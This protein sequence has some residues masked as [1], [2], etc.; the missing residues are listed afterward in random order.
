MEDELLTYRIRNLLFAYDK[1]GEIV[2]GFK[3]THYFTPA[4]FDIEMLQE[5]NE[6]KKKL[7]HAKTLQER[8]DR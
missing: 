3:D 7:V 2:G 8:M 5:A 4:E 1:Q 6:L